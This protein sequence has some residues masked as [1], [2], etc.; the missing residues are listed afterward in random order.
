MHKIETHL[1]ALNLIYY[2]YDRRTCTLLLDRACADS[3]YS[4]EL[5]SITHLLQRHSINYVVD[6]GKNI[7]ITD[8]GSY[9]ARL[10]RGISNCVARM[11][12]KAPE[13]YLLNDK[14]VKGAKN[15]PMFEIEPQVSAIDFASYD[16]LIVTSQNALLSVDTM[17]STWKTRPVYAIAP[18]TAQV[19]KQLGGHLRF[20]GKTKHGDSFAQELLEPLKGQRVLYLRGAKSV[21]NLTSI[22]NENGVACDEAIV[23]KTVCKSYPE[24]I[25]LPKHATVIFSSPSTIDCFLKNAEWDESYRAIAIGETT[26]RHFPSTITP[27]IADTTSLESCVSKA[28]ALDEAKRR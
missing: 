20:V 7:V 4:M 11:W 13:I 10:K 25:V 12:R 9:W 28:I 1:D 2:E 16:A 24:K 18:K 23:Y 22:L 27:V 3:D 5:V 26:A 8:D 6:K 21:S 19:V 15:L 14:K 17:G